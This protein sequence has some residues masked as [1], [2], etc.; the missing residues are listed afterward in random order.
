MT[1][2]SESE[3]KKIWDMVFNLA[4]NFLHG[5]EDAE[6]A[7][8]EIFLKAN[9]AITD[10]RGES[11]LATWIYRIAY[12][13]LVDLKRAGFRDEISFEMFEND[14]NTFPP[15]N[16][17]LGLSERETDLYVEEIKVGCTKAMLQCLDSA[18][19]FAYI[20]GKLFDFSGAE[21]ARICGMTE[22]AYRQRLSRASRKIANF[23]SLNCGLANP[24][25][26]CHCRKRIGVALQ[27]GRINPD[28]LLHHA[29]SRK[30]RDY[31][32]AMNDLDSVAEIFRENPYIEKSDFYTDGIHRMVESLAAGSA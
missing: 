19:R 9:E 10:F 3:L 14:V 24:E 11:S 15:F 4:L 1:A 27:R 31:L 20:V 2:I 5:E 21:G 6:E 17:E 16:N 30:I 8:Q 18:D 28:M 22:I 12:N 25:A 23:M 29:S 13:H 26:T 7:A 32:S